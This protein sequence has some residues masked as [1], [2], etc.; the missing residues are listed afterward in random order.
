M[1][2]QYMA[3][4]IVRALVFGAAVLYALELNDRA[5]DGGTTGMVS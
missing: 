2:L 4:S 5:G 1:L 3:P